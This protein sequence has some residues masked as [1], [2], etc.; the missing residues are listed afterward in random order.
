MYNFDKMNAAVR[1]ETITEI[2]QLYD[3][4]FNFSEESEVQ[5]YYEDFAA[6]RKDKETADFKIELPDQQS[7]DVHVP[8]IVTYQNERKLKN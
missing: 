2:S 5:A 6:L 1:K 8:I 4:F 3:T 7:F